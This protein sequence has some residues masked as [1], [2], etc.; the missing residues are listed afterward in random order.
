MHETA[1]FIG[2]GFGI[3]VTWSIN[4]LIHEKVVKQDYVDEDGNVENFTCFQALVGLLCI[5]WFLIAFACHNIFKE[6]RDTTRHILYLISSVFYLTATLC[7]NYALKWIS[8]PVQVIAKCAK[9]IPTLILTTIIGKRRYK[10]QKYFFIVLIVCGV[11]LFMYNKDKKT[12]IS[13]AVWYGE[14]LLLVSLLLDGLRSGFEE[15]IRHE[16]APAPFSMMLAINGYSAVFL[17][18]S[19]FVTGDAINFVKFVGKYPEVLYLLSGM[20]FISGIGQVFIYMMLS[21]FGALSC[22][23]VTTTRKFFTVLFSV[24]VYGHLIFYYQWIGV[25]MVFGGLFADIFFGDNKSNKERRQE[26]K[27]RGDTEQGQDEET[28]EMYPLDEN[29]KQITIVAAATTDKNKN[30]K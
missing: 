7:T 19:A 6:R 13:E 4:G 18:I 27:K 5:I 28:K 26:L 30:F 12:N 11:G 2:T 25:A 22:S 29:G 1:K 21:H 24:V 14:I 16:S 10:C 20:A 23:V 17:T 15:R 3:I 8:Y 9:P